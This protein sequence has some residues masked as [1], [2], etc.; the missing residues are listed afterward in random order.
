MIFECLLQSCI[1]HEFGSKL[2]I[3]TFYWALSAVWYLVAYCRDDAAGRR[4]REDIISEGSNSNATERAVTICIYWEI[5]V[6]TSLAFVSYCLMEKRNMFFHWK[7][8]LYLVIYLV[9]WCLIIYKRH[10]ATGN[11]PPIVL[12]PC[13]SV[14]IS[15]ILVCFFSTSLR[16]IKLM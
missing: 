12:H 3:D 10:F 7:F 1:W 6:C 2:I 13:G 4:G 5:N 16:W 11:L 15:S 8:L 9:K 14:D